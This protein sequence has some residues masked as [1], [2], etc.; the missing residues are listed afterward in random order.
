MIFI[1]G[2][3]FKTALIGQIQRSGSSD[4][5]ALAPWHLRRGNIHT[6]VASYAQPQAVRPDNS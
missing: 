4:C 5:V 2:T 3:N 1:S 6:F